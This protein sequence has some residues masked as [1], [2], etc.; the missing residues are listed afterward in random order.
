MIVIQVPARICFFGDHQDYLGLPVIA[1][2]INQY[3]T[4][5]ATVNTSSRFHVHLK[6]LGEQFVMATDIKDNEIKEGDF[7][8]A[9]I[10]VLR[11]KGLSF[12]KGY[13]IEISGNIPI[14]AGLSSSSAVTVAWIRFLIAIQQHETQVTDKEIGQWAYQTEVVFFKAPGGIMDH[15]SIAQGGL[16]YID[17]KTQ[18]TEH[19]EGHLGDLVVAESGI[20]KKTLTVLKNAKVFAQNAIAAIQK[21]HPDFELI[22]AEGSDY[23]RYLNLVPLEY[24]QHWYAAVHNYQITKA[25]KKLLSGGEEHTAQL[26]KLMDYHQQI[27]QTHIQNTPPRMVEMIVAAKKAGALGAK[28]IGSGGGGCILTMVNATTKD[29]VIAAL[30][31]QGAVKAYEVQLV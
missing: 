26:G 16:L 22:H 29:K 21:H 5:T 24:Q 2:T 23:E 19:L 28:T 27:L 9:A 11:S 25:A 30:L 14:N 1:G 18:K 10:A 4:L 6:D 8:G 15:L 31:K 20:P 13:T 17:T 7:F 12:N 3:I